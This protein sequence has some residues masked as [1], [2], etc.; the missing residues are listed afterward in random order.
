MTIFKEFQLGGGP[1]GGGRSPFG[2]IVGLISLAVFMMAAF[3]LFKGLFWMLSLVAPVLLITT[4]ILDYTVVTDFVKFLM[5]SLK[6]NPLFGIMAIVLSLAAYPFTT[7]FLF[8]RAMMRRVIMKV[9]QPKEEIFADGENVNDVNDEGFSD[10]EEVETPE[11]P[12]VKIKKA[13]GK[14]NDH[15]QMFD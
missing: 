12:E 10:Y 5:K 13:K 8:F 1:Q 3:F 9:H 11:R 7:G 6:D 15:D 4:L 2:G 14:D